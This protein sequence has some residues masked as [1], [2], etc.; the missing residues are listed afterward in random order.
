MVIV[1]T[2]LC[3]PDLNIKQ[4]PQSQ[5]TARTNYQDESI[6][7]LTDDTDDHL[8]DI[9]M[10]E[11][12]IVQKIQ[13]SQSKDKC[14]V[15]EIPNKRGEELKEDLMSERSNEIDEKSRRITEVENTLSKKMETNSKKSTNTKIANLRLVRKE[16]FFTIN[17]N[18]N[19]LKTFD[20]IKQNKN[21]SSR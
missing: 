7:D 5:P 13:A 2:E 3:E 21:T 12:F 20:R 17:P 16:G 9:C 15:T 4:E 10:K 14:H 1:K 19:K 6:I 8:Q 18:Q 11:Q